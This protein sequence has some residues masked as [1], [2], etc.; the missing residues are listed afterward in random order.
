MSSRV[1]RAMQNGS[2][3]EIPMAM[4]KVYRRLERWRSKRRGRER[5]PE[6]LWAAAAELARE[7]GVNAVSRALHLE[8]N[9]LKRW[10]ESAAAMK[11]QTA[12]PRPA[13]VEVIAPAANVQRTCVVEMEGRRGKLR[14]ELPGAATAE[15]AGLSRALWEMVS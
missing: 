3:S 13:F 5:I 1:K 9:Q 11:Q 14:I 2:E 6:A 8:F 12:T 10:A 4:R 15:L 7:H